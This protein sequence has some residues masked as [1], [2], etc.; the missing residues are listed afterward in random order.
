MNGL[1]ANYNGPLYRVVLLVLTMVASVAGFLATTTYMEVKSTL[2]EVQS[3]MRAI[4]QMI[5][6]HEMLLRLDEQS[7]HRFFEKEGRHN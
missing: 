6:R 4:C 5:Q 3:D 1:R 2:R 7:R